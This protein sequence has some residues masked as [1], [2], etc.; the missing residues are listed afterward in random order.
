MSE[1]TYFRDHWVTI[2]PERFAY[3]D[4]LFRL[5]DFIMDMLLAPL[6]LQRGHVCLDL[7]CGPGYVS[8]A[9]AREVGVDGHVHG[10]DVNE[11]FIAKARTVA[12]D[13]GTAGTCTFHRVEDERL[14][15]EDVSVD[16]AMAKNVLEYVPDL[17]ATLAEIH[18]VLKP[19]GRL[20]AVDSDWG[21]VIVEPLSADEVLELFRAA[22]PAFREPYIGRK[23]RAAYRAAGF[24]DVD[25]NVVAMPDVTG[26]ARGVLENM[27]TYGLRFG[28][29]SEPRADEFRARFEDALAD[30]SYLVVVPQFFVSGTKG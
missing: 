7:G 8:T 19:G 27:L 3:Y 30:G 12:A 1:T 22:A 2:E 11:D 5:P 18:R 10:V 24:T 21:F 6:T 16:R 25:V 29:L 13:A 28:R 20:T 14:P 26:Q 23:L 9:M 15:L 4:A 17:A